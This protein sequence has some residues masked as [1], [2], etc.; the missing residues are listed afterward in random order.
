MRRAALIA[1]LLPLL[2]GGCAA[3][4]ALDIVT[5]PVKATAKAVD[6]STTSQDEADRNRGRAARKQEERDAKERHRQEKRCRRHPENCQG[7]YDRH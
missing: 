4:T 2:A 5:F 6:W 1:A 7:G 3:R